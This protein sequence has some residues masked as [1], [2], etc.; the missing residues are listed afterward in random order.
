MFR[1]FLAIVV[2][3][4][5]LLNLANFAAAQSAKIDFWDQQRKGA[6]MMNAVQ[7]EAQFIAAQKLGLQYVRLAIDKWP[8]TGRDFLIGSADHYQGLDAKDLAKLRQVLGWAGKHDVKVVLTMLSLPGSRWRQLN[9]DKDDVRLWQDKAYW[10]QAT[11]FWHDLA[12]AL[13]DEDVVVGYNILNEPHPE[14]IGTFDE[15]GSRDFAGWY[16]EASGTARDLNAFY[17][18]VIAAIREVDPATPIMLDA[19]L[20]AAPDAFAYLTPSSDDKTLYA[21]H[22]YE[23]YAFAAP[24][25]KGRFT[26]PGEVP[27]A[28][29]SVRWDRARIETYLGAVANWAKDRGVAANRIVGAEFGCYRQNAGCE[30]YLADVIAS[31]NA[32]GW[33]WAFY[34]FR[35]DGWDGMDYEVGT[36]KLPWKYW[37]DLEAG[38]KPEPPRGGN[39]LF[40]VIKREF[41]TQ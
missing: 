30:D 19:G 12:D 24:K 18:Q 7:T 28:G 34:A 36:G 39:P 14:R 5:T 26:Y 17:A 10:Q 11:A 38:K 25:N 9:G 40:A 33:H 31:L 37:Q 20:Y 15:D 22:M 4:S 27:F 29:K 2:A 32:Q 8:A 35:E 23:P 6:N 16:R 1:T 41:G 3:L 13:K 21:F